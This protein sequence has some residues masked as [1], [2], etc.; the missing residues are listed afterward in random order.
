MRAGLREGVEALVQ[1]LLIS[2]ALQTLYHY[3]TVAFPKVGTMD[4]HST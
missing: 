4:H 2:S 1:T 3:G